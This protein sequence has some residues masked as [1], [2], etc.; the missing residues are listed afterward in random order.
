MLVIIR[1]TTVSVFNFP[2]AKIHSN[3]EICKLLGKICCHIYR[4]RWF[5]FS[6]SPR[7]SFHILV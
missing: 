6:S 1:S 7:N 5:L 4:Y 3:L 2:S